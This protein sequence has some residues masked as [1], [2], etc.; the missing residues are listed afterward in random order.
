[1]RDGIVTGSVVSNASVWPPS[2]TVICTRTGAIDRAMPSKRTAWV[3]PADRCTVFTVA[4]S[5]PSAAPSRLRT[6]MTASPPVDV[7]FVTVAPKTAR[8]PRDRNR[9]NAGRSVSGLVTLIS[10][11]PDPNSVGLIGHGHDAVRRQRIRQ[12]DVAWSRGRSRPSSPSQARRRR[13][14]SPCGRR[15]RGR[16]PGPLRT[17]EVEVRR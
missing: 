12:R 5:N 9:G 6:V 15:T 3:S 16:R 17:I 1:M 7:P 14:G 10:R 2:V 11:S 8:S 4:A 13:D